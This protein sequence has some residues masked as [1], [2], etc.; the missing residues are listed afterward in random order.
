MAKKIVTKTALHCRSCNDTIYLFDIS[1]YRIR[2]Y[3]LCLMEAAHK[4]NTRRMSEGEK[5]HILNILL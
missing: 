5:N 1:L 2:V 4:E 3:R